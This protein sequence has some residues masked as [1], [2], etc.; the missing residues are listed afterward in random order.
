MDKIHRLVNLLRH[1]VV[2]HVDGQEPITIE[3]WVRPENAIRVEIF[4][5]PLGDF[6][7]IPLHGRERYGRITDGFLPPR[8]EGTI[9]IV[10]QHVC[11]A[12][13]DRDD[14]AHPDSK[15]F[16]RSR[17]VAACRRLRLNR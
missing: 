3:P 17:E 9:Y 2:I 14:L 7:G 8:E 1:D 11:K 6:E 12:F 5:P 16:S 4:D 15:I 13:P 10:P